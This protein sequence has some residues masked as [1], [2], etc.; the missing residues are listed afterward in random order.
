MKHR[1]LTTEHLVLIDAIAR[2]GS[3]AAAADE[4]GRVP[5]A[6]TYAVRRLEDSLD[7]LLFDRR[8]RRARLT[9][10]G[11]E[12]LSEG[13]QLLA[14]S[15]ELSRRVRQVASGWEAEL[16]LALDTLLPF[17]LLVQ[18]LQ[19]FLALAPTRVKVSHE[20][21]GGTWDALV[22]GRADLA[23]GAALERPDASRHGAGLK[24]RVIGDIDFVFAIAP[25]HPL[26]AVA[27]PIGEAELRRHRQVVAGDTSQRLAP[28]TA[29]L[30]GAETLVV[31]SMEAKIAAQ[32]GG[33]GVGYLPA[34]RIRAD[35]DAGRLLARRTDV[36][37]PATPL[38]LAW[39]ASQRGRALDW[40][41]KRLSSEDWRAAATG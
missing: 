2:C 14:A 10:A 18:P 28:R 29:G 27:E 4:L 37:K 8:G 13:R 34:A 12:L 1:L 24:S 41:V 7:V 20:V 30:L 33:L 40:W 21:L 19:E 6:I 17:E 15:E 31:P 36:D 3:F 16:R 26:A 32:R 38:Q 9:P 25:D 5:S 23:I 22:S 35:L 11:E 39:H